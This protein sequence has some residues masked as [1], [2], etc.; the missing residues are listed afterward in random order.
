MGVA[1]L[2]RDTDGQGL[3][4]V[5]IAPFDGVQSFAEQVGFVRLRP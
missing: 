3:P 4:V 5:P 1:A 2:N